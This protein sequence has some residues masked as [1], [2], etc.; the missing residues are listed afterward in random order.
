MKNLRSSRTCG[1]RAG[2]KHRQGRAGK[3]RW[4][5][6]GT[7]GTRGPRRAQS[8]RQARGHDGDEPAGRRGRVRGPRCEHG[9]Q[10]QQEG[11][12]RDPVKG[13]RRGQHTAEQHPRGGQRHPCGPQDKAGREVVAQP[14][15]GGAAV[16][17][18]EPAGGQ[19][20]DRVD[21]E[22]GAQPPPAAGPRGGV[23]GQR[24]AVEQHPAF[25]PSAPSTTTPALAPAPDSCTASSWAAPLNSSG[26]DDHA[27]SGGMRLAAR[28]AP[29]ARPNGAYARTT[30]IASRQARVTTGARG[31][32]FLMA[33]GH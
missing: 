4:Q 1:R 8:Q 32:G 30:G 19:R 27:I 16:R 10:E 28:V 15:A 7:C 20:V 3:Q 26:D 21:E 23:R 25:T 29:S 14:V 11:Q 13:Q 9:Q 5:W 6:C 18:L 33:P 12:R 22:V 2:N 17:S 31:P 24:S